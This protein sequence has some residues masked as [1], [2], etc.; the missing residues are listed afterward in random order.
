MTRPSEGLGKRLATYRRLAGLSAREL[1]EAAGS[2]LT[3]GVIANIESGRKT[4]ITVD[5][6][7]ALAASLRIN[8]VALAVPIET[9]NRVVTIAGEEDGPRVALPA[10]VVMDWF[11]GVGLRFDD[12]NVA[13]NMA[14]ER[15]RQ[16]RDY[17]R[18]LDRVAWVEPRLAD[19]VADADMMR[20]AT[21]ELDYIERTL[22]QLGV[23]LDA[24]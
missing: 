9:P 22:R 24:E 18:A 15:V 12:E 11:Q 5:Q 13:T 17:R 19:G 10:S 16:V 6:L 3:R 2:G 14:E 4:D 23:E 20:E 1:A 21:L 7:I 8:P